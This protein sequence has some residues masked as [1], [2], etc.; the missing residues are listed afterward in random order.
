MTE[1]TGVQAGPPP[2]RPR[3][4]VV[5]SKRAALW[6]A[7]WEASQVLSYDEI[8]ECVDGTLREIEA[9]A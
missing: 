4:G 8:R 2:R 1:V 7:V 5:T 9:D 3:E 6:S